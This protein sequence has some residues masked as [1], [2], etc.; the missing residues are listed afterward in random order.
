M[1]C[2][3]DIHW[4][5][6]ATGELRD[7]GTALKLQRMGVKPGLPD[8]LLLIDGRLHGLELKRD[9]GG[10]V[11]SDQKAIHHE[12]V[13]AGAIVAVAKGL[14]EALTIL[15]AWGAFEPASEKGSMQ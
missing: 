13:A 5:H 1:R 10:R 15:D 2:R 4:H 6:P 12:L 3:P 11:S 9:R 7:P 14:D 8:F